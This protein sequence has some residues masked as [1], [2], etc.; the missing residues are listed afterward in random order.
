MRLTEIQQKVGR[1]F[2]SR[3]EQAEKFER[4][5]RLK[6]IREVGIVY[7]V[8]DTPKQVLNKIV[9]H[10]ESEG[11][12]VYTLGYVP[13]KDLEKYLPNYKE[14]YFCKQ[15]VSFWKVPTSDNIAEFTQEKYDFLINLDTQ[16]VNELQGISVLSLAKTRIGKYFEDYLFAHDLMVTNEGKDVMRLFVDIKRHIK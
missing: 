14:R 7:A 9:H 12:T 10:F 11:K 15:D 1:F 3:M 16:G 13:E 8:R 5:Q 2:L 4:F 6:T